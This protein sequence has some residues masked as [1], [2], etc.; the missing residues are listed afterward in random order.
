MSDAGSVS[1][2]IDMPGIGAASPWDVSWGDA[3]P[4]EIITDATPVRIGERAEFSAAGAEADFTE[5]QLVLLDLLKKRV[6]EACNVNSNPRTRWRAIEWC[7]TPGL[8]DKNGIEFNDLCAA[9][10]AR[11][12][13]VRARIHHQ[14]YLAGVA[15]DKPLPFMSARMPDQYESEALMAA[16]DIGAQVCRI[17]WHW[18]GIPMANLALTIDAEMVGGNADAVFGKLVEANL[19]A[20]RF[21]CAFLIGRKAYGRPRHF[22]WAKSFF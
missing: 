5:E 16:W 6:R 13:V 20:W 1:M 4:I 21:G 9:L 8:P 3:D 17:V 22:S 18:P 10:G 2:M 15:L 12:D 19:L 11:P 7:F 14:W